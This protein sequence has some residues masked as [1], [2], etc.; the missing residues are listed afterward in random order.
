K[1]AD[2]LWICT[3]D[4][5]HYRQCMTALKLGYHLMVEKPVS[6]NIEECLEIEKVSKEKNL[7]VVVCHVLRYSNYYRKI[8][9]LL[10]GGTL[11]EIMTINH[12]E[13]IA[14]FH[15]AHSYVRGNWRQKETSAPILLA[16]CCHDIDL[17]SWFMEGEAE[18]VQSYGALSYFTAKNAPAG[19]P[20]RCIEG[21]PDKKCPYNAVNLYLKDPFYKAKFVKFFPRVLTNKNKSTKEDVIKALTEGDYGRCV[22]KSPNNVDDH[23]SL[24]MRFSNNRIAT[25]TLSAFTDSFYRKTHITCT[26]GEIIG[27]DNSGKLTVHYFNGRNKKY[28]TKK[29]P[30]PGHIEGDYKLVKSFIDLL[31]GNIKDTS[32]L[33]LISA[34]IP[35][36]RTIARAEASKK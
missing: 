6:F 9:E 34:T 30:L 35:S 22:F 1:R 2:A 20:E 8:K 28:Y 7:N 14:Y 36:H 11:G 21:C 23:Q 32:D 33:T 10:S 24:I 13:N 27:N 17:I 12:Q 5:L 25:H 18:E 31:S 3:G 15:Y 26:K 16:K 4:T 19:A 29:L